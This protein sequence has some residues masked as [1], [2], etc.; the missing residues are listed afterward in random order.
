MNRYDGLYD[1]R[2]QFYMRHKDSYEKDPNN[3]DEGEERRKITM[4]IFLNEEV[5][6]ESTE[7]MGS[8]RLFYPDRTADVDVVPRMGRAV[9]FKSEVQLHEVRPTLGFDNY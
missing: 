3:L 4:V 9:L 8:L 5:N 1:N 2:K 7:A 6:E